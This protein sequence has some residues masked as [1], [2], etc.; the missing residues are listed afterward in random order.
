MNSTPESGQVMSR[1]ISAV[2]DL[3]WLR[4]SLWSVMSALGSP[5]WHATVLR[6][7]ENVQVA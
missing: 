5:P 3:P 7:R 4:N 1:A 6:D 2:Q